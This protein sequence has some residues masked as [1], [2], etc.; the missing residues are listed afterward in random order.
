MSLTL[1]CPTIN[2]SL[3]IGTSRYILYIED[4]QV[5]VWH[6]S[7]DTAWQRTTAYL[8]HPV[9]LQQLTFNYKEE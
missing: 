2:E 9:G 7:Q 3:T 8:Q 5:N 1:T 6:M 4:G